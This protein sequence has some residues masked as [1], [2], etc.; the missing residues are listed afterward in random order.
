[1]LFRNVDARA[2][3]ATIVFGSSLYGTMTFGWPALHNHY[4]SI[5]AAPHF[6]H[7]M[8]VTVWACVGFALLINRLIFGRRAEFESAK[9]ARVLR[10]AVA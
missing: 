1:L 5:P 9:I 4:A 6:L 3:I 7:L 10:E 8:F 2:V